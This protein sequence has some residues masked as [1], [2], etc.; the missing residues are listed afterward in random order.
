MKRA[1]LVVG[2]HYASTT[3]RELFG[4]RA[5]SVREVVVVDTDLWC[6]RG[7]GSVAESELRKIPAYRKAHLA[8]ALTEAYP[9][10]TTPN[11]KETA[12]RT[13]RAAADQARRDYFEADPMRRFMLAKN[14]RY[15]EKGVLVRR[16]LSA[17]EGKPAGLGPLEAMPTRNL[18]LTWAS[19][20]V[21]KAENERQKE[22]QAR[23][24]QV[25]EKA[26]QAERAAVQALLEKAF[27]DEPKPHPYL[28]SYSSEL[29]LTFKDAL[30][31]LQKAVK[32]A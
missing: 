11:E 9:Q 6:E 24:S 1:D 13:Y 32:S 20:L 14:I 12:R 19:Y 15:G 31:L 16:V 8:W 4:W 23:A 25:A 7:Y 17:G 5:Y 2:E 30:T 29:R 18:R 26:R 21:Q 3:S 22:A 27:E 28:Y 10:D